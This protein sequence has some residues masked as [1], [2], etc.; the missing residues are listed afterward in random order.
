MQV[1]P[2][3]LAIAAALIFLL[4]ATLGVPS[5]PRLNYGWAGMF[6]W[7]LAVTVF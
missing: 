1:T 6:C 3:T 2:H 4:L 7:L 5:H